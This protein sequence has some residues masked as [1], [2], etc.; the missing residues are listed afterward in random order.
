MCLN[1]GEF[2]S[3]TVVRFA[4][5]ELSLFILDELGEHNGIQLVL[6]AQFDNGARN[7]PKTAVLDHDWD[8]G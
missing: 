7:I 5:S 8:D 2:S 1:V 4:S 3:N 6:S